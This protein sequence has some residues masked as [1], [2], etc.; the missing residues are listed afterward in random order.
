M[1]RFGYGHFSDPTRREIRETLLAVEKFPADSYRNM[2]A[3]EQRST[4]LARRLHRWIW[5]A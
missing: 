4:A 1:L 5:G 2:A 3:L